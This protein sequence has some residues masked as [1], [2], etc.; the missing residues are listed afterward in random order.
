MRANYALSDM[1]PRGGE[2]EESYDQSYFEGVGP[3]GQVRLQDSEGI[4]ICQR[5]EW[6]LSVRWDWVCS[7]RM[8]GKPT[9]LRAPTHN[10]SR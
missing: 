3:T 4:V 2:G 5:A 8:V 7:E 1:E 9:C 10:T 6:G